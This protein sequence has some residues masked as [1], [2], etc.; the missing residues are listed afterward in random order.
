MI[1]E[2]VDLES[3]TRQIRRRRP[4][5]LIIDLRLPNGSA[6]SAIEELRRSAPDTQI[7]ALTMEASRSV[8]TQVLDA[9]AVGYVLKEH[10]D[11]DLLPAVRAAARRERYV[12]PGI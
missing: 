3:T 10:S 8:A 5:V 11:R 4:H 9:G 7:V 12:S 2:L 1:A 6:L